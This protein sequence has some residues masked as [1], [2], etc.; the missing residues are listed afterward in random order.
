VPSHRLIPRPALLALA[1]C[2]L[3]AFAQPA[4][5]ARSVYFADR[6][7]HRIAQFAVGPGGSLTALAP[8]SVSAKA[9]RRLAMTPSGTDLYATADDAVL[10]FHVGTGG[11]LGPK[12]RPA[13]HAPGDPHS[14]AVHPAGHSAYVTDPSYGKVRQYTIGPGG[15]LAARTPPSVFGLPAARGVA[16]S[17]AGRTLYVL[18]TGGIAVL[19]IDAAGALTPRPGKVSVPTSSLQDLGIT[20]DGRYLYATS[21]DRRVF[22]FALGSDGTPVALAIP[23]VQ[24][25]PGTSPVGI[26]V[27]PDASAVYVA[28]QGSSGLAPHVLSFA[29]G[30]DG[31]LSRGVDAI[32][33]VAGFKLWYLTTSPNG[34]H[35]FVGGDD[36][37]LFDLGPG[38]A[39]AGAQPARVDLRGAH[40]VVVSPNQAPVASFAPG[41]A[42]AGQPVRFDATAASDPDGTIVRYDWDFGDGT[43]LPDGGPTPEHVYASPG[44]YVVTLVVT[45]NEGA[46]TATV[47]TGGTVLGNGTPGAQSTQ[48]IVVGAS[49]APP[50]EPAQD[51]LPELGETLVAE[52]VAGSVRVR[53]PG[54]ERFV[55][56]GDVQELP[57]GSVL[58]TRRGRVRVSTERRRRGLV[59]SGIFY[60][61][62]FAVRQRKRDRYITDLVL[63]GVLAPCADRAGRRNASASAAKRRLWGNA[64]G[65][66]RTRGRHSA[67]AVRG[68]RWLTQDSCAGTLT[69]VRTGVV[70]VRDF[71]LGRTILVEAGERYLAR[72]R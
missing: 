30:A 44:A 59:Q 32:V 4:Q 23:S 9:P 24:T 41:P 18:V 43:R 6:S 26:A 16:V 57:L 40:G 45:D 66:F 5:A 27:A 50:A 72:P 2:A 14:I 64:N 39:L 54:A 58:D 56:L 29:V 69:K 51:P 20:P 52:P 38:A 31:S 71:R 15:E 60:G 37:H 3:A 8:A 48:V 34:R 1:L 42:A 68:T 13:V 67:G 47:F 62:R 46:S 21:Q 70:A 65:R 36:G 33:A 17:P 7:A 35:L 53:L 63:R 25:P 49:E 19:D 28:A 61:G 12:A 22:Q 11:Q 55:A 10:Q